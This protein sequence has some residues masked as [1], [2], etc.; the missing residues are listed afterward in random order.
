MNKLALTDH[1]VA[2]VSV[3][4]FREVLKDVGL[5][6]GQKFRLARERSWHDSIPFFRSQN[7]AKFCR[8]SPFYDLN[9]VLESS[10]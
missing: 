3:N 2:Q 6:P 1:R 4:D 5:D 7:V 10:N 8:I 9:N